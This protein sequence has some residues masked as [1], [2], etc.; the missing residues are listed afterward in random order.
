MD[1]GI[2]QMLVF[3]NGENFYGIQLSTNKLSITLVRRA[4]KKI[5]PPFVSI[6][7]YA[8]GTG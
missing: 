1:S 8:N 2:N 5:Q 4:K 3:Y 7:N 6:F